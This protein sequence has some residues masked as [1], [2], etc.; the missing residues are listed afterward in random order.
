MPSAEI[1]AVLGDEVAE[2]SGAIDAS[3]ARLMEASD[4]GTF[5]ESIAE[6]TECVQRIALACDALSLIGLKSVCDFVQQNLSALT[7]G[8]LDG[9]RRPLFTH[10]PRL[11]LGYLKAPLDGVY[12]RELAELLQRP[13]WPSPLAADAAQTL[14]QEL[15]T[16]NDLDETEPET[17]RESVALPEDVALTIPADVNPKL[18]DAFLAEGPL[19]AGEYSNL[20]QRVVRGEAWIDELNECRRLIHALKGASNTVGVRGVATLCHHVEDILEYLVENA[21]PPQAELG[22]LLIKVA[23][24]LEMMFEALLDVGQAP[25]DA[26]GVLQAVLDWVNRID[27]GEFDHDAAREAHAAAKNSTSVDPTDTAKQTPTAPVEQTE[28]KVRVAVRTLDSLLRTAGELTISSSHVR[29]R[30][31]QTFKA[32]AELRER[33]SALWDRNHEMEAYVSTQGIAAGRR[34][35]TAAGGIGSTGGLD[36]LELDQYSELHTH[37]QTITEAVADLQMLTGRMTEALAAVD[38]AVNQQALLHDEVHELLMTSRMVPAGNLESRLKRTVRQAAEQCGKEAELHVEGMEVRLDDQMI[39]ALVDPLQHLLRNAVDHGL[40]TPE[41]RRELGK[42]EVGQ[43]VLGFVR[44]GNYLSIVC[45]DDGAGLDAERIRARALSLGLIHEDQQLSEGEVARLILRPGFS[46]AKAVT[47]VSGRGVGMDIVHTNVARLKGTIDIRTQH[48]RGTTFALRVPM[49]LGIAHCLLVVAEG[50]TFA[51][52]TDNLERIVY[53]GGRQVEQTVNGRL[54][55]DEEISCAAH[56][57]ASLVGYAEGNEPDKRRHVILMKDVAGKLAIMVDAVVGGSDLVIKNMGRYLAEVRG[58][59]GASILGDGS[60]VP[61]LALTELLIMERR[62]AQIVNRTT[63]SSMARST[64]PDILVVDDSLSVR[65]ALATLLAGEGFE[66]RTAKDGMEAI[67]AI[68]TKLPGL[69]LADF[70]MPRMNGLE[71][72]NHI[73][74][75]VATRGLP[76]ILVTSRTAEKHRRLAREAGVDDYVTKPYREEDLLSRLR[77]ILNKAA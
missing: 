36:A 38:T 70:E 71:L 42:P 72:T 48:G 64:Q 5:S 56:S 67:E 53:D 10:W 59:I 77:M 26:L 60:V 29:E 40:E 76:V 23:D 47:E 73:R 75:N 15:L 33:H 62:E 69:V 11:V 43:I 50:Q 24:T 27:R 63:S 3:V 39:N 16:L 22:R 7:P 20:I 1:L 31:Q 13:A 61:I 68:G 6:Y 18:V 58:M 41:R 21:T 66:V 37:V 74:T 45:R 46:T 51:L 12:T 34:Q 54:Y 8:S 65:T 25:S 19:Q 2:T 4:E 49:S 9:E 55:R 32:F 52:P 57:L 30:L 28:P 44:D 14:E 35:Q 17:V